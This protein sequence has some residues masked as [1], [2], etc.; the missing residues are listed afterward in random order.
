MKRN[1]SI[2]QRVIH[3]SELPSQPLPVVPLVEIVGQSRVLIENHTC[4]AAYNAQ[5]IYARVKDGMIIIR[6]NHLHLAYMSG[7]KLVITGTIESIHL[8]NHTSL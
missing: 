3:G 2:L 6:G 8:S 4:I 7:E 5:E 1:Q